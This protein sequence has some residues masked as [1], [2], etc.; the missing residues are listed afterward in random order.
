MKDKINGTCSMLGNTKLVEK[1]FIKREL[2][3]LDIDERVTLQ[4]IFEQQE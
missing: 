3:D 2:L 1:M 4:W